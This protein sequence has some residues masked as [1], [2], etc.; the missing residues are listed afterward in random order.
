MKFVIPRGFNE[1]IDEKGT[2]VTGKK[3]CFKRQVSR[4]QKYNQNHSK[5]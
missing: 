5:A 4:K 1:T 2:G 3:Q